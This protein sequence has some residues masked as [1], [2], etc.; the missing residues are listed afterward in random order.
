MVCSG[1]VVTCGDPKTNGP[2]GPTPPNGVNVVINGPASVA[3]GQSAQFTAAVH[4]TD[5]T[6]KLAT[7]PS[8][9][10]RS[11]NTSVLQV[12]ASG[13]ATARPNTGDASLT[14][15][16][17][18][19]ISVSSSMATKEV[20]VV[21]D[22]TYRLVGTV[23]DAELPTVPVVGAFVQVTPGSLSTRTDASGQYKLYGVPAASEIHITATDYVP[24]VQNL[25]LTA[26]TTQN[27]QLALSGQ[28]LMLSGDYTLAI[29]VTGGCSG[30]RP[31]SADLQHR[32]Y[33]AHV[34]QDGQALDVALTDPIF[35]LNSISRGNRFA[36]KAGTT[37]ASFTLEPSYYYYYYGYY[38][39]PTYYPNVV[40]RLS[41]VT[42]LVIAGQAVTTKSATG[43]SGQLSGHIANYDSK[44]PS[45]AKLLGSCFSS[46]LQF[47]LTK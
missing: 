44:F 3:P 10:W 20:V 22:G 19:P 21:P 15:Q 16:V 29:D 31:L 6:T 35:R 36:G 9:T 32:R 41:N 43:V 2:T 42:Y 27:F 17:L 34:T 4:F 39:G 14:A 37:G 40:E 8:V 12:N 38:Y 45:G 30:S 46:T 11:S 28:R 24:L 25:Q 18:P 33:A 13:V 47:S 5:G 7:S 1:L 23:T 26:H